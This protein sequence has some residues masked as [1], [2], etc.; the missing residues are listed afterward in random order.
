MAIAIFFLCLAELD[1]SSDASD[2]AKDPRYAKILSETHE[3]NLDTEKLCNVLHAE[4]SPSKRFLEESVG[5]IIIGV[6]YDLVFRCLARLFFG[7]W[8]SPWR[9]RTD[10]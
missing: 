8:K 1:E 2:L 3:Q 9:S 10:Y 4:K 7:R 6:S 5:L